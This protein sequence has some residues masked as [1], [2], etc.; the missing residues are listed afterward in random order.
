MDN[1]PSPAHSLNF[2]PP[3]AQM[4]SDE[5]YEAVPPPQSQTTITI[6]RRDNYSHASKVRLTWTSDSEEKFVSA[7]GDAN[8]TLSFGGME[9]E[10]HDGTATI[11][12][13]E[14]HI[15]KIGSVGGLQLVVAHDRNVKQLT[16]RYVHTSSSSKRDVNM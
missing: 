16:C 5:I 2:T 12:T 11:H 14:G 9:M 8:F 4:D 3:V 13:K 10:I 6:S 15:V 7:K 1:T